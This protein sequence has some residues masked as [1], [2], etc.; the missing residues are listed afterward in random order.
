MIKLEEH[1]AADAGNIEN[2]VEDFAILR[3][4]FRHLDDEITP[5]ST[6]KNDTFEED[7]NQFTKDMKLFTDLIGDKS[8]RL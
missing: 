6:Y 8:S 7:W 3:E 1:K 2:Y 5:V 4:C